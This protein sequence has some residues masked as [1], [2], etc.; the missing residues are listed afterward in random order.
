MALE[1]FGF[2]FR[3]IQYSSQIF[4]ILIILVSVLFIYSSGVE[5]IF[6]RPMDIQR[7]SFPILAAG[8]S[9]LLFCYRPHW[10]VV[11]AERIAKLFMVGIAIL[12]ACVVVVVLVDI[13][14]ETNQEING[15][16]ERAERVKNLFEPTS[17]HLPSL[18][19]P[20]EWSFFNVVASNI[21]SWGHRPWLNW[22]NGALSVLLVVVFSSTLLYGIN[23]ATKD[24]ESSPPPNRTKADIIADLERRIWARAYFLKLRAVLALVLIV[25]V[26]A[27]GGNFI[28]YAGQIIEVESREVT[29]LDKI[30]AVRTTLQKEASNIELQLRQSR[31]TASV[32]QLVFLSAKAVETPDIPVMSEAT[33]KLNSTLQIVGEWQ[34]FAL[35]ICALI[36]EETLIAP[37]LR[38]LCRASQETAAQRQLENLQIER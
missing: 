16:Q 9:L 38:N 30:L 4:A 32:A 28:Y 14:S 1:G 3:F 11:L 33:R 20:Q 29:R 35:E 7:V 15:Y 34:V 23:A 36:I 26:L 8:L 17:S 24:N 6:D 2:V 37:P 12:S 5:S 18:S 10:N 21:K 22:V 31:E 13:I 25:T 19:P 27:V